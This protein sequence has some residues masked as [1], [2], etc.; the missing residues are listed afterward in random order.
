MAVNEVVTTAIGRVASDIT[1]RTTPQGRSVASFRLITQERRYD[2][3]TNLWLDGD[4]MFFSVSC[5][6]WTAANVHRSLTKGDPVVV[7]GRL[8]IREYESASGEQRVSLDLNAR[9]VGP[10]LSACSAVV[11]R[12][13]RDQ[14]ATDEPVGDQQDP[15]VAQPLPLPVSTAA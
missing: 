1:V 13:A 11:T 14:S 12:P 8:S 4:R 15:A 9:A 3:E 10:D 2:K 5:W 7:S 6:G